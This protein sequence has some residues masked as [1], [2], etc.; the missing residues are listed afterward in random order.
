MSEASSAV[1]YM[2]RAVGPSMLNAYGVLFGGELLSWMDELSGIAAYRYARCKVVTAAV[3]RASFN[4]PMKLGDFI[5]LE[6]RVASVGTSS[7][8]ILTQAWVDGQDRQGSPAA[9]SVFV[10][11]AVDEN[12]K[13][14]KVEAL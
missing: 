14:R 10:Y 5:Q 8:R 9:E 12:G 13:P 3:E 2:T 7:M 11:V 1:S 4:S 6:S